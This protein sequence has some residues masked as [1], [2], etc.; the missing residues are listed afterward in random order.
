MSRVLR[1]LLLVAIAVAA[2]VFAAEKLS[3][4]IAFC[5]WLGRTCG[6]GG[7]VAV[8]RGV[9]IYEHDLADGKTDA[10]S[11]VVAENLRVS[12]AAESVI[13]D[14]IDHEVELLRVQ[15]AE[16]P[17]FVAA[18]HEAGLT[19]DELRTRIANQLR[20]RRWIEKQISPASI[21]V[22]TRAAFDRESRPSGYPA[23]WRARHIFRAA[24]QAT[25]AV[26]VETQRQMIDELAA[27]L[28]A[29]ED[30]AALA[31]EASEDE[32]TKATG[33]DLGWFAADRTPAEFLAE[34]QKLAVGQYSPPFRSSLGFHIVQLTAAEP[35]R[36]LTAEEA[37][38]ELAATLADQQRKAAV[39]DLTNRLSAAEF[40]RNS[41]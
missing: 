8:V 17:G 23:R 33:G 36:P 39:S 26:V 27:R 4:S 29:G 16:E 34:V 35:G 32:A 10:A 3:R 13:D 22:D 20:D 1:S 24:H 28:A 21:N 15:F 40:P 12:A 31:F 14:E 5:D 6:R 2:G 37:E 18:L 38:T 11:A 41:D 7:L 25:P 9:D 19:Q 30:F